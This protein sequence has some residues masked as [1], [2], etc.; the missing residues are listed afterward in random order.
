MSILPLKE[1]LNL[2][3]RHD[4][5]LT[6]D[7]IRYAAP[8]CILLSCRLAYLAVGVQ[9]DWVVGVC[10]DALKDS[11][12]EVIT[13]LYVILQDEVMRG[14]SGLP[15]NPTPLSGMPRAIFFE[16]HDDTEIGTETS[17]PI[18]P[19]LS[20]DCLDSAPPLCIEGGIHDCD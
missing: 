20:Y 7:P 3:D 13:D 4:D 14:T 2:V 19:N 9:R 5:A 17:D 11:K 16:I 18:R 6:P 12:Q 15:M 1:T 8:S 10:V